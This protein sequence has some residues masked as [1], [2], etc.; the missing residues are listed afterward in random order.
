MTGRRRVRWIGAIILVL[1]VV[2]ATQHVRAAAL[3]EHTATVASWL[4]RL[5]GWGAPGGRFAKVKNPNAPAVKR[6]AEEDWN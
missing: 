1:C 6:Q 2:V 5:T 3:H 4:G